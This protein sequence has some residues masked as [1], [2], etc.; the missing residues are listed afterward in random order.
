MEEVST[1]RNIIGKT[2]L[3]SNNF[4]LIQQ[5]YRK[6]VP[7]VLWQLNTIR[8]HSE[9]NHSSSIAKILLTLYQY[10]L[11]F[12]ICASSLSQKRFVFSK[13]CL[14]PNH[15]RI[16]F[17]SVVV[18]WFVCFVLVPGLQDSQSKQ[19]HPSLM[20]SRN[21]LVHKACHGTWWWTAVRKADM[22]FALVEENFLELH[23]KCT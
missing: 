9:T 12:L 15:C 13:P 8:H 4:S 21:A 17:L 19:L 22:H 2:T 11:S 16:L 18:C 20:Q 3:G 10:K 14:E 5:G 23:L 6:S 7:L 1:P